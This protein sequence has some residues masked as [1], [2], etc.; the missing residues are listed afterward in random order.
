MPQERA[1]VF[2]TT[3][4]GLEATSGTIVPAFK[5]LLAVSLEPKPMVP[6]V[7]QRNLGSKFTS[8]TFNKKEWTQADLKGEACFRTLSYLF[9][10]ILTTGVVTTPGGGT[11]SRDWTFQPNTYSPDTPVTFTVESGSSAGAERFPFGVLDSLALR[12]TRDEVGVS[13][14]MFGQS[15]VEAITLTNTQ[16]EVYNVDVGTSTGGTFTLTYNAVTSTAQAFNVSGGAL[17]TSLNTAWGANTVTVTGGNG[18]AGT[19]FI[20]TFTGNSTNGTHAVLTGSGASLT[21]GT[22]TLTIAETTIGGTLTDITPVPIDPTQME[23]LVS[24]DGVTYTQLLRVFEAEF[25][26]NNRF[27]QVMTLDDTKSSF[28][29]VV[30]KP[31]GVSGMVQ[32][33]HD[34]VGAGYMTQLRNKTDLWFRILATGPLIEGS[35]HYLL[36]IDFPFHFKDN[37]RGDKNDVWSSTYHMEPIYKS[38]W[39]GGAALKVLV[40]NDL[41]AL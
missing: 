3:Q 13:G 39:N 34:S 41:T 6:T 22:H 18:Q 21:G 30:E 10:S 27:S 5:R 16:N 40:Q 36:Q 14:T 15:L 19:P 38:T 7:A 11:L 12:Y 32:L 37:T 9:S 23:F 25:S 33:E 24:T 31:I 8:S 35:L 29:A 4:V 20:I 26:I 1:T 17:Q 2:E 28:S